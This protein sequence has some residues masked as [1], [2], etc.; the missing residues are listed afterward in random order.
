MNDHCV[1]GSGAVTC[2]LPVIVVR[3]LMG[4]PTNLSSFWLQVSRPPDWHE[5][6]EMSAQ[7]AC[8]DGLAFATYLKSQI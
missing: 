1:D 7:T 4:I 2:T 8:Y 3:F 6:E 5:L